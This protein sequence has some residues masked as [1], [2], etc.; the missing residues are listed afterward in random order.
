MQILKQRIYF[1]FMLVLAANWPCTAAFAD[2]TIECTHDGDAFYSADGLSKAV[3]SNNGREYIV[4]RNDRKLYNIRTCEPFTQPK[5]EGWPQVQSARDLGFKSGELYVS[6]DGTIVVWI[7]LQRF[8]GHL[9][10]FDKA[11]D[12]EHLTNPRPNYALRSAPALAVFKNGRLLKS[13]DLASLLVHPQLVSESSIHTCWRPEKS[14]ILK[15][16]LPSLSGDG[17]YFSFATLGFRKY[18]VDTLTGKIVSALYSKQWDKAE[19]VAWGK[20]ISVQG[21]KGWFMLEDFKILKGDFPNQKLSFYDSTKTYPLNSVS[22]S[23]VW[24]GVP[25]KRSGSRLVTVDS[26]LSFP[27]HADPW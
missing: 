22:D 6:N 18:V 16:P 9:T 26:F 7:L 5:G 15:G 27:T 24:T 2:G 20:L 23:A 1:V 14:G 13:Y 19:L 17:R 8:F 4:T 11:V 25:L 21:R 10:Q 3:L 12:S